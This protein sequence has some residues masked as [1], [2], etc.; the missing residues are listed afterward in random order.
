MA[1]IV[2]SVKNKSGAVVGKRTVKVNARGK[3]IKKKRK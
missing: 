2:K 1:K 3:E